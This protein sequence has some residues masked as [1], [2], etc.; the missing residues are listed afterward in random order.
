MKFQFLSPL[1]KAT[2]QIGVHLGGF[3]GGLGLHNAEGHLVSYL[4][5]YESCTVG[6]LLS[7]F[8]MKPSTAT[9]MLNRL[10]RA[11]LIARETPDEDRRRVVV[12][13]T[14]RGRAIGVRIQ[15]QIAA[16]EGA[17]RAG[18]SGADIEG[19]QAVMA[20]IARATAV[21]AGKEKKR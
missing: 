1:H 20:A 17:I 18:V 3:C 21:P 10:V 12:R 16:L 7:V 13:L 9:S 4:T 19:F 6:D 14:R 8:G 2:R 11:G 15:A 5:T